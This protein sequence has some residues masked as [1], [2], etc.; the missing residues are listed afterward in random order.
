[1]ALPGDALVPEPLWQATRATTIRAS[2][3]AVWPWLVQMGYPTHRAGW[4]I[5]NWIDRLIF[6]I[7]ARS[8]ER[9][10]PELQSLAVGDRVPDSPDAETA[11]FRV[12]VLEERRALVLLS[13]THPLP[14][15]R[16]AS[17]SWAFVL[18][19]AGAGTRLVMRARITY[20]P[21]GPGLIVRP[22]VAALFGIGDV[23]QA[24]A[25]LGGIRAR[26]EGKMLA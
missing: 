2:R 6:G 18:R 4:Y 5:P 22:A 24:G 8:A 15:Y 20:T 26:A 16:D 7:R 13:H 12:A 11:Y 21:V 19:D 25:M 14:V 17:F 9:I 10:I 23:V 1:M 3:G